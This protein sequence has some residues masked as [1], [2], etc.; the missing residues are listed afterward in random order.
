MPLP[1]TK[2]GSSDVAL[3]DQMFDTLLDWQLPAP[4]LTY[5]PAP[6]DLYEKDG[7]YVI[8]VAVP[9]YDAEEVNVEVSGGTVSI[10]GRHT[11]QSERQGARYHRR[12]MRQGSF[13]RTVTLPQ[14]LDANNVSA[15]IDKGVLTVELTPV[16]PISPQKI[17]VKP[18]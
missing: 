5:A 8:E 7:K 10:G 18:A 13:S 4:R 15:K 2:N 3:L 6:L 1:K 17:E 12:E 9:G 16:K 11:E 14:D